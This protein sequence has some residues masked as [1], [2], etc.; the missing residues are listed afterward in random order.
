MIKGILLSSHTHEMWLNCKVIKSG[1]PHF[2]ITPPPPFHIYLPFLVKNFV[3]SQ[4]TQLL[5]GP[6]T[7]PPHTQTPPPLRHKTF[8]G[9]KYILRH[10]LQRNIT[11]FSPNLTPWSVKVRYNV[12]FQHK[13][14][15]IYDR[16]RFSRK[17]QK[18]FVPLNLIC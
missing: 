12:Y 6:T 14:S 15:A 2:Y 16:K 17:R 18:L 13:I 4:V 3:P 1:N 8:F 5:Q 10:I 9:D 11:D 7:P